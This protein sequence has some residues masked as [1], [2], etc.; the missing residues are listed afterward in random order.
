MWKD[1][2]TAEDLLGFRL[3]PLY[4]ELKNNRYDCFTRYNNL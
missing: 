1:T 2:E 4:D 3:I